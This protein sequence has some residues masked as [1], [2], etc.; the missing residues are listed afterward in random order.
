MTFLTDE[1]EQRLITQNNKEDTVDS[2][3][4][5]GMKNSKESPSSLRN[6]EKDK[7]QLTPVAK[8]ECH[9]DFENLSNENHDEV[10]FQMDFPP[11]T[12][13]SNCAVCATDNLFLFEKTLTNVADQYGNQ[14]EKRLGLTSC[15][16]EP[17]ECQRISSTRSN[18]E[19]ENKNDSNENYYHQIDILLSPQKQKAL[20]DWNLEINSL[21]KLPPELAPRGGRASDGSQEEA[22]DQWARRR[23]QFKEG[24]RCSSV[25]GSSFTSNVTEGS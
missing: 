15:K 22:V 7:C 3:C 10:C 16:Q 6:V 12:A 19:D 1:L 9:R 25:G 18:S 20:K 4:P 8:N 17:A 21:Q 11:N 5:M 13:E 23:Q 2:N 24:K 14:D